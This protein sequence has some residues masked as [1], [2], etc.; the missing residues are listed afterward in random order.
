MKGAG[1]AVW[2]AS[3]VIGSSKSCETILEHVPARL[4]RSFPARSSPTGPFVPNASAEVCTHLR[5]STHGQIARVATMQS[6]RMKPEPMSGHC[7]AFRCKS[8]AHDN[9]S[10]WRRF[11]FRN[12][13][14][15]IDIR[16]KAMSVSTTATSPSRCLSNQRSFASCCIGQERPWYQGD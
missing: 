9:R 13:M 3:V 5:K 2:A 8:F 4:N 6:K 15:R 12:E 11:S 16:R 7:K 14:R 1:E 10:G